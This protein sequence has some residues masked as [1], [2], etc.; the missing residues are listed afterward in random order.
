MDLGEG[1]SGP[2]AKKSQKSLTKVSR[3]AAPK[4][5]KKSR[6]RSE[7][8]PKTHSQT[9]F[10]DFS[11]LC[12]DFFRTFGAAG[13]ETFVGLFWD[14][15]AFGPETPSPRSTEPQPQQAIY[16]SWVYFK[17]PPPWISDIVFQL[18]PTPQDSSPTTTDPPP[19]ESFSVVFESRLQIISKTFRER[20]E[21]D[22]KTTRNRLPGRGGR[23]W[24][25]MSP[26]GWAVAEK[27]CHYLRWAKTRALKTDT[28]ACRNASVLKTLACW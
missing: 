24:W 13:R 4:V 8:S 2:K 18:Q 16:I 1:V 6:K 28:L 27:Q 25:G 19:R 12:R 5:Q 17:T 7:K 14:F 26:G 3:P 9:Y 10:F 21:N 11:D 23:W 22:R 20:L 15:F